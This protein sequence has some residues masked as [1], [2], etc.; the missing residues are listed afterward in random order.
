VVECVGVGYQPGIDTSSC[1]V[2]TASGNP[3][4]QL[5][6]LDQRSRDLPPALA[7]FTRLVAA[8]PR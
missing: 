6:V 1:R 5:E 8:R 7:A 3:L 4:L 2:E